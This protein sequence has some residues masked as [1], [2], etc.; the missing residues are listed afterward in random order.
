MLSISVL[1]L[2]L[3]ATT[4]FSQQARLLSTHTLPFGLQGVISAIAIFVALNLPLILAER[5]FPGTT[6]KRHYWQGAKNWFVYTIIYYY[7]FEFSTAILTRLQITP[8]FTWNIENNS[9]SIANIILGG[10]GLF[11]PIFAFDMF[12]YWFHRAQHRFAF[13]W[14][15][16]E[17]HHSIVDMNCINSY[18]HVF[19]EIL[20]FPFIA[21]PLALLL[22][23]NAPQMIFVSAFI[24]AWG[25]YIH[26]DTSLHLGKLNLF[27]ADNAVHRIHH[28]TSE[29]HFDKNFASFFSFWDI[30]FGTY[31]TPE[32]T[33][34]PEVGLAH[35]LPPQSV[36][37]YF[38]MPFR[39]TRRAQ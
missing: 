6:H 16:H 13:L 2:L 22:K 32:P 5:F 3:E 27:F 9:D 35:T 17:V 19:E 18:H 33:R 26:S 23:V 30:V 39:R 15:F 8:L 24:A 10:I 31:Q 38:L 12:Y 37:S 21:I 28:S 20:R 34:L 11:L 7:W 25:Q 1:L 36:S 4:W 29:R 14:R